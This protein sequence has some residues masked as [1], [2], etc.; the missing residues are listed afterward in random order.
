MIDGAWFEGAEIMS[1]PEA[2]F[3]ISGRTPIS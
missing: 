1:R 3:I 2:F